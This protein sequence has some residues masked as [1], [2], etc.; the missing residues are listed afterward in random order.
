MYRSKNTATHLN[1]TVTGYLIK[2]TRYLVDMV[3]A[4]AEGYP[5]VSDYFGKSNTF[6]ELTSVAFLRELI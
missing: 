5:C 6:G 4:Y 3:K 1:L 2:E